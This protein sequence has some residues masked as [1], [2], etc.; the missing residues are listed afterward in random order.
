MADKTWK[1]AERT[2]AEAL[3]GIRI[4]VTGVDRDGADVITPL[5]HVQ[6]KHRKSLPGYLRDWL[7]GIRKTARQADKVGIVVLHIP[8]TPY[9]E[10][11]V[12]MSLSDFKDLHGSVGV[13]EEL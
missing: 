6:V 5:L 2:V 11:V 7:S 8:G 4:P 10:S 9:A 13:T 1:A 12:L 3:G